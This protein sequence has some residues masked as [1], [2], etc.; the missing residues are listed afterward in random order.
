[1]GM[2]A[3]ILLQI[4]FRN[5]IAKCRLRSTVLIMTHITFNISTNLLLLIHFLIYIKILKMKILNI[6]YIKLN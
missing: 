1:M 4:N 3:Y 6:E 2:K 5:D